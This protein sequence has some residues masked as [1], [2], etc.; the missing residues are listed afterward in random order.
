LWQDAQ[1]CCEWRKERRKSA[2][3]AFSCER[4]NQKGPDATTPACARIA[5]N[6]SNDENP[7][8]I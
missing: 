7:R 4:Q 5:P 6:A 3:L 2:K 8:P 1:C